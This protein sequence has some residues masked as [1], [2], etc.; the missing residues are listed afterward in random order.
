MAKATSKNIKTPEYHNRSLSIENK[1]N[2][3]L[4]FA[5]NNYNNSPD[6]TLFIEF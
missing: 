2:N 6:F 1:T 5:R 4:L 3:Q